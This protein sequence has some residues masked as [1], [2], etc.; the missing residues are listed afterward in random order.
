MRSM[1]QTDLFC[2]WLEGFLDYERIRK[3]G[4]FSLSTMRFLVDRCKHPEAAFSSVHVAGSKGKG[5]VSV[6]ISRI[7]E[8]HGLTCGLYLS[9]H[10]VDFTERVGLSSG[11]FSDELYGRACDYVVPLVDSIIPNQIPGG[12]EPSWFELV[13]LFAFVTFREAGIPWAVVETGL[14][15]RL[16][17]TNVLTPRASVI[18]RIELEHTEYLGPTVECIAGEKAGI[19]KPGV[20][21]FIAVQERSVREVFERK[22]RDIGARAFFME[23]FV[24]RAEGVL[25]NGKLDVTL[26]FK[27]RGDQSGIPDFSRPLRASLS[28]LN[29]VQA[30]NAALAAFTAKYL[31]PDI[32]EGTIEKGLEA[33]WLP[34][35]FEVVSWDPLIVLDGAHTVESIS[36]TLD[37][38]KEASRG[39]ASYLVFGCAADKNVDEIAALLAPS[40]ERIWITKPGDKKTSD[41]DRETSAFARA[42]S[43]VEARKI[44]SSPDYGASIGNAMDAALK[45]GRSLLITGSFY[46]VAEAKAILSARRAQAG[47]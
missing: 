14:G 17:A 23:D 31:F 1:R 18:T 42:L 38:F 2:E 10:M 4:E 34:G 19:M 26:S 44:D 39:G 15:G 22:A 35:R 45:D 9:P 21:A 46:L 33:A 7:I 30:S 6:M 47:N 11:P 16:D 3:K 27:R 37:T 24:E 12:L 40:F 20:G 29:S 8:A 41:L 25:A 28:L 13:T 36:R 5:S 32:S 43:S